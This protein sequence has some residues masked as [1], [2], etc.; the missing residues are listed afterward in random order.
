[1]KKITQLSIVILLLIFA[2]L[3]FKTVAAEASLS[4]IVVYDVPI[5][6]LHPTQAGIGKIQISYK[7]T[8]YLAN[9]AAL[10]ASFFE[11]FNEDNGYIKG[12]YLTADTQTPKQDKNLLKT[13]NMREE[14][15]ALVNPALGSLSVQV[16]IGPHKEYYAI[17]GHHG[18][19]TNQ[20]IKEMTGLGYDKINVAVIADYSDLDEKTFW[21]TM[22]AQKYMYPKA[23]NVATHQYETISGLKL[24]KQMNN[25]LFVNDPFRGLNYFWRSTAINKDTIS[26]PFAEFYWGEFMSRT[27]EFDELNFQTPGDYQTAFERGNVIFEKLIAGDAKYTNLFNE[28]VTQQYGITANQIALQ[29]SYS[30]AKLAKQQDKLDT[31]KAYMF[32][33]PNLTT[34]NQAVF[35]GNTPVEPPTSEDSSTDDNTSTSD[36]ETSSTASDDS[37]S[38]SEPD[39][40]G[41]DTNSSDTA[42]SSTAS[43]DSSSSAS[44]SDTSGSDTNSSDTA[45]SSTDSADSSSSA[46]ESDTSGSDTNSSDTETS[47]T[48]S[49]NSSSSSE[50]DTSGSDTNSSDTATSSTN[51][52]NS[53]SSASESDT[54]GSDTNSSSNSQKNSSERETSSSTDAAISPVEQTHSSDKTATTQIADSTLPHTGDSPIHFWLILLGAA[55]VITAGIKFYR[56]KE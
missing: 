9:D 35:D 32:S 3:P 17:D 48:A 7:L 24:P 31:A 21:Q 45:T 42:T 52:E 43:D 11:D 5:S 13:V 19:N 4:P 18:S 30:A 1:M 39:T 26:V 27:H 14:L 41:S 50:S 20:L 8:E 38:S 25:Q 53:S 55:C 2:F 29:D 16:V 40:S 49:D 51:G 54:S 6:S 47:S 46:N 37:S 33:H 12:N 22:L 23:Y 56:L 10:T 44:E 36:T 34:S 28:V 15:G